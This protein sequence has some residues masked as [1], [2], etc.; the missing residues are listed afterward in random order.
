MFFKTGFC[1]I[2]LISVFIARGQKLNNVWAFGDKSGLNFN[3]NP[4]SVF[5]SK[6]DGN[7]PKRPP[8]FITS[9][10]DKQGDLKFYTD[11][12]NVWNRDNFLLPVYKNWWPW[13]DTT[14]PLICPYPGSDSLYYLFAISSGSYVN[15]LQYLTIRMRKAG[16][17]EEVIY[18][19]P[20]SQATYINTLTKNA[21]LLLAGTN[22]CNQ[23]DIWIVTHTPGA[24]SS[25]L[26]TDKGITNTAVISFI[27][28]N[29]IP[30]QNIAGVYSNIKFSASGEKM[31]FPLIK[32]NK[33]V[34]FDFNNLTGIFSNPLKI[35]IPENE[36]LEDIELS[37]DGNRLYFGSFAFEDYGD[38]TGVDMHYIYQMD[39][40]A[41]SISQIEKS[42]FRL[43]SYGDRVAC[44]RTC[45]YMTRTMQLAPDGKIY[46]SM[47]FTDGR[48]QLDYTISAIEEPNKLKANARYRKNFINVGSIYRFINYNY[49]RSLNFT[50]KE[51]G[52]VVQKN[53]CSDSPAYFSLLYN[54]LDSVK[55]DFGDATSGNNNFSTLFTPQHHYSIP[56]SYI[57]KAVIYNRCLTDTATK[58]IVIQE[59]K[60][61]HVPAFIKDTVMCTGG[62]LFLNASS[63]FFKS[64]TWENGLIYSYRTITEPGQYELTVRNDCSSDTKSFKV[65]FINCPC[66]VYIPNA[67]TPNMDGRNDVFKAVSKCF[68]RAYHLK[69]FNRFGGIIFE[70]QD[71]NKGWTGK[72][73]GLEFPVGVYVWILEYI[74]PNTNK[75]IQK[76]GTVTLLR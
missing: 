9:I 47:R 51:Q 59:N 17:F 14:M 64:Y 30:L 13:S 3:T 25:F 37:S 5:K 70:T 48:P 43:N 31:V 73:N 28:N 2:F 50:L 15:Q 38:G 34:V 22:H 68:A 72:Q 45:F 41:G 52:I 10:C 20:V 26:V 63:P 60:T 57:V 19:R 32:E 61:V 67:F 44:I 69:I 33:I 40:N 71:V 29:I 65:E 11:G 36:K 6:S 55:W 58:I 4:V 18:P 23:K 8:Y 75:L 46:I 42:I 49:I 16:D 7:Q 66:D 1:L 12:I 39:L 21:S 74:N 62:E 27:P 76:K 24:L 35:S 53:T 54:K 56:G